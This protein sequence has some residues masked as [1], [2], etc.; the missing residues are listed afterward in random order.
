MLFFVLVSIATSMHHQFNALHSDQESIW[1]T[2][3]WKLDRRVSCSGR[4]YCCVCEIIRFLLGRFRDVGIKIRVF[5]KVFTQGTLFQI[6]KSVHTQAHMHTN[7]RMNISTQFQHICVC[8]HLTKIHSLHFLTHI[9]T[10]TTRQLSASN[11]SSRC[12][13]YAHSRACTSCQLFIYI[14]CEIMHRR[15]VDSISGQVQFCCKK[16]EGQ[17]HVD[18]QHSLICEIQLHLKVCPQS[19]SLSWRFKMTLMDWF[20]R[21]FLWL[22][23][24]ENTKNINCDA[25]RCLPESV[26]QVSS[27]ID[28]FST[29]LA[30]TLRGQ[31]F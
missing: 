20:C 4:N 21:N 22:W 5:F 9:H 10:H 25:T 29:L 28:D 30:T 2:V 23:T 11:H 8:K 19:F 15:Q 27:M 17:E 13:T 12:H 7:T 18:Q 3:W 1:R 14:V 31:L 26:D 24:A 6:S 16:P